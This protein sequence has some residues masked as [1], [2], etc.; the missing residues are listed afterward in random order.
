MMHLNIRC[1]FAYN[2]QP[3]TTDI[4]TCV[5]PSMFKPRILSSS[6]ITECALDIDG[7]SSLVGSGHAKIGINLAGTTV[8]SL[9]LNYHSGSAT[10]WTIHGQLTYELA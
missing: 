9:N 6:H 4:V 1:D 8:V 5:M 7:G 10:V 2:V 3:L